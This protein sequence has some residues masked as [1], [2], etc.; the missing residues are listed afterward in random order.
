MI[1][2]LQTFTLLLACA[3]G[4]K[5]L[6]DLNTY[7]AQELQS[8]PKLGH[9]GIY[10]IHKNSPGVSDAQWAAAIQGGGTPSVSEDNPMEFSECQ[11]A[12][13]VFK[14]PTYALG[15]HEDA[16]TPSATKT[17]LTWAEVDKYRSN[18]NGHSVLALTRAYWPGSDWEQ[19]C[20]AILPHPYLGG[21]A[22][23]Y[24]PN[25]YGLRSEDHFVSDLLYVYS[26]NPFFLWPLVYNSKPTEVNIREAI[27][28]MWSKGV[29]MN[30]NR[31]HLVIARYDNPHIP[32]MGSTNSVQSAINAAL[33]MRLELQNRTQTQVKA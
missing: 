30:D 23:E 26:R 18:C 19:Y 3:N 8:V 24:N 20:R 5:V 14:G 17:L 10:V 22:M 9:D 25:D 27:N 29:N 2:S 21:I 1:A 33:S 16:I 11:W 4:F 15:Y 32:V 28:W 13:A 31:I 12:N 6:I 7:T